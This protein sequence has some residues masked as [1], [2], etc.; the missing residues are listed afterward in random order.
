MY[1]LQVQTAW[2]SVVVKLVAYLSRAAVE[3]PI[4]T[5]SS[6][7]KVFIGYSERPKTQSRLLAIL[8]KQVVID[9]MNRAEEGWDNSVVERKSWIRI[10]V[11]MG[12]CCECEL[13]TL[14]FLQKHQA[15]L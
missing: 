15:W 12:S 9:Q 8:G 1:I 11:T 10:P 5:F 6:P 14:I 13:F 7:W 2:G 4:N 3:K